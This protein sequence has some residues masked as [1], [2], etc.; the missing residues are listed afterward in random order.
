[1]CEEQCLQREKGKEAFKNIPPSSSLGEMLNGWDNSKVVKNLDRIKM[2]KYCKEVWVKE[3]IQE[4][5]VYWPWYGTREKWLCIPLNRHVNTQRE[6][7]DEE[8]QC[9]KC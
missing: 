4:G 6:P 8:I 5:P 1:M 7:F 9:V 2:I 3:S